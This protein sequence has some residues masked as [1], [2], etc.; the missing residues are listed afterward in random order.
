MRSHSG[1]DKGGHGSTAPERGGIRPALPVSLRNR[2]KI[3]EFSMIRHVLR[4]AG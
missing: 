4:E 1:D 3:Q 2:V